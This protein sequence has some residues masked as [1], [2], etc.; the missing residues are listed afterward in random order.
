MGS[1][2]IAPSRCSVSLT[3]CFATVPPSKSQVPLLYLLLVANTP[4]QQEGDYELARY[5]PPFT[6]PWLK[7]NEIHLV[8][9]EA[10]SAKL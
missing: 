4:L 3:T 7:T 10:C 1:N 8:L 9:D 2:Y 5:N 6:I